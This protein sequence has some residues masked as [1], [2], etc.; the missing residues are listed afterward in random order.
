M[1]IT[2]EGI[3][4]SGKTTQIKLLSDFLE[5][6]G[7]EVILIREPGGTTFSESIRE[8]LLNSKHSINRISELMLFEAARADLTEKII[9]PALNKGKFV[10]SDRFYDSTTAYQGYGRGIDLNKI[11][12]LNKLGALDVSPDITFY[13]NIDIK[14]SEERS[15]ARKKDRI[16][17][18]G[19]EFYEKVVK[20]FEEISKKYPHRFIK[21]NAS[22]D[23]E[24][25]HKKV[26]RSVLEHEK[27]L[28]Y[29]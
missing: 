29:K 21:I 7:Y 13:L 4:G 27:Y 3:D 22:N 25:T 19:I 2:F 1:F 14:T 5:S 23:I 24:S 10:L 28:E 20:G 18:S 26:L 16:E 9:I 15:K 6:K 8:L 12:T 11:E 17:S